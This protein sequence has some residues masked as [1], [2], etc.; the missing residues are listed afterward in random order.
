[1]KT[2]ISI[3]ITVIFLLFASKNL[4]SDTFIVTNTNDSGNGSLRE[5]MTM[6]N[7][8]AGIDTINFNIPG[9]GP[10]TIQPNSQLPA[11]NDQA[12]VFINGLSQP[13]A[14]ADAK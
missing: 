8:S 14:S 11:L 4:F 12:G 13:G 1:M 5:A 7:D 3:I 2:K 9:T 6:A 10:H